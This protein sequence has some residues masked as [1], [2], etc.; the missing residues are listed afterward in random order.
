MSNNGDPFYQEFDENPIIDQTVT[1]L[2]GQPD[3]VKSSIIHP[4]SDLSRYD[5]K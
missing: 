4:N 2:L 5:F 1:S 3:Y